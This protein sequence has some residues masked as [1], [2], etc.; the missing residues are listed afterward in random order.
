MQARAI[1]TRY[2]GYRFRSRLEARWAVFFDNLGVDWEYETEG[3]NLGDAGWYLPDFYLPN[4]KDGLWVEIKAVKPTPQED[5]KLLA[6]VDATGKCGTFRVGEPMINVQLGEFNH[7]NN[8]HIDGSYHADNAAMNLPNGGWDAPYIFC[9]CNHCGK[10]GFEFDGRGD[11]VCS[12]ID[13]S[14]HH[15]DK[16]YSGDH[17]RILAAAYAARAA[18]FEHG[19]RT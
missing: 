3:Y 6:L 14:S 11:R 2:K 5:A 1:E 18:R 7:L 17:P 13:H 16:G 10:I 15:G 12:A 8:K 19:S 9:L 4:I